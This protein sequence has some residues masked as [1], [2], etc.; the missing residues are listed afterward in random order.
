MSLR[1]QLAEGVPEVDWIVHHLIPAGIAQINAQYKCGKTTF[2]MNFVRSLVTCEPF[3]GGYEVK[4]NSD[5]R[6]GYLNMELRRQQ[7]LR[8]WGEMNLPDEAQERIEV[9]HAKTDGFEVLDFSN[10]LAVEWLIKWLRENGITVLV[11]DPLAKLHNPARWG[12]GD[13]N[14]AYTQW[15]KVLEDIVRQA[16]LRSVFLAHHTGFAEDSADRAR[17]A[18]AMMDNPDVNMTFRHNGYHGGVPPDDKRYLSAFGRDVEVDEFEIDYDRTNRF[19]FKTGGFGRVKTKTV[20]Q[21][22]RAWAEVVRCDNTGVKPNKTKLFA[23]LGW[24]TTGRKAGEC[25]QWYD[26]AISQHWIEVVG[27]K[28]SEKLHQPGVSRPS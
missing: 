1:D 15:W 16:A 5:E 19:L 11:A 12:S 3:L 8:W 23:T 9:Y 20:A 26:H 22:R 10:D 24:A 28:G 21:A 27:G 25:A 6:V 13:P 4:F 7:M 2:L 17:G 14:A 18:S